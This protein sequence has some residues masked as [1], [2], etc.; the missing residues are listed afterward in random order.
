MNEAKIYIPR[1]VAETSMPFIVDI[2]S[3]Y[4]GSSNN[5]TIIT[6]P[7][8]LSAMSVIKFVSNVLSVDTTYFNKKT[9][10]KESYD[11][12]EKSIIVIP[13]T[14]IKVKRSYSN[15]IKFISNCFSSNKIYYCSFDEQK[16]YKYEKDRLLFIVYKII[17]QCFSLIISIPL[18][19]IFIGLS[20]L[21]IIFVRKPKGS[22]IMDK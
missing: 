18:F 12:S 1:T 17:I 19:A 20:Y 2:V 16:I 7:E 22:F 9:R 5:I 3:T 13:I 11:N 8:N 4:F 14:N 10:I 21:K 15:V 6:R